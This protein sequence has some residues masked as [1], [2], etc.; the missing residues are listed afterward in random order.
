MVKSGSQCN[1]I[2]NDSY[3]LSINVIRGNILMVIFEKR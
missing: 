1:K 3:D 2:E